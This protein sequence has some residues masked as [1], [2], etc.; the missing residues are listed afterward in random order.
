MDTERFRGLLR[1]GIYRIKDFESGKTI[2]VIQDEL[3]YAVGKAGGSVIEYWR[4]G[5]IPST[6]DLEMLVKQ[7]VQRSDQGR[8]WVNAIL[9][10]AGYPY[11]KRPGHELFPVQPMSYLGYTWKSLDQH[12]T[13]SVLPQRRYKTLVGRQSMLNEIMATLSDPDGPWIRDY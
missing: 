3:G 12:Q 4:K 7:V 2:R 6:L 9:E 8:E 11:P 5:N 10:S 1:D 13:S